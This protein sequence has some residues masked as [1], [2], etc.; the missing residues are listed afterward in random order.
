MVATL[1]QEY[2]L[3]NLKH[4]KCSKLEESF[5]EEEVLAALS[6]LNGTKHQGKM[7]SHSNFWQFSGG[8]GKEEVMGVFSIIFMIREDL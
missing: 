1:H 8:L 2:D 3:T 5:L 4:P 6:N 7:V